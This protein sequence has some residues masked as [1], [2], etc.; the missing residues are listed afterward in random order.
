MNRI[1]ALLVFFVS[2]LGYA[3]GGIEFNDSPFSDL[4]VEAGKQDKL[5]FIDAYAVWCGPCKLMEKNV[6]PDETV[7]D[8]YNSNFINTHIDMEKG[9]GKD[10][11]VT[12]GVNTFPHY[13]FLDAQGE[14]LVRGYGYLNKE[15]LI[16]LG[17]KALDQ[18]KQGSIKN[19][20]EKGETD[21]AFLMEASKKYLSSEPQFAKK[22]VNRYFEIKPMGPY[23]HE[24]VALLLSS[25]ESTKD[26]TFEVF[27]KNKKNILE[28]LPRDIYD[29]YEQRI[30]LNTLAKSAMDIE[31]GILDESLFLNGA[32]KLLGPEKGN[33]ELHR[34]AMNFYPSV[35]NFEKYENAAISYLQKGESIESSVLDEACY[36]FWKHIQDPQALSKAVL[37]AEQS[38]EREARMENT[39]LLAL[40]HQKLGN[41]ELASSSANLA[42]ALVKKEGR[43]PS[44]VQELISELENS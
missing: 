16:G 20:F 40:L 5:I 10:L 24:E 41:T 17:Q 19:R 4:L 29:S 23:S 39:Y 28:L 7:G 26:K 36:L 9:E 44:L 12:Y 15:A 11:A 32:I 35:G 1:V 25:I 42:L 37:W 38:V 13:L 43:D 33:L 31:K 30:R 3:K 34:L 8:F 18:K 14:V 21:L 27:S 6:F 2:V 22:V